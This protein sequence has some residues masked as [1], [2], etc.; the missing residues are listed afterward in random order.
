MREDSNVRASL[1]KAGQLLRMDE[2][3]TGFL[4]H[5]YHVHDIYKK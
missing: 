5:M 3:N 1:R 2:T 4:M